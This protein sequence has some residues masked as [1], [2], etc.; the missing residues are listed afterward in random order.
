MSCS[1]S[2]FHVDELERQEQR[3]LTISGAGKAARRLQIPAA[4]LTTPL[5]IVGVFDKETL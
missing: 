5:E 3:A 2:T 4:S 1:G